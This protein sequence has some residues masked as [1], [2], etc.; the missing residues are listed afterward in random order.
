MQGKYTYSLR[1]ERDNKLKA[2]RAHLA[3]GTE[4]IAR[5]EGIEDFSMEGLIQELDNED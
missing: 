1:A 5:G 2:L 3:E 4:Q